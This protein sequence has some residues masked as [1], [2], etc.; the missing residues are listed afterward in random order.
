MK[1][2]EKA[3][4]QVDIV[5]DVVCP[6]CIIG[7]KQLEEAIKR[8]G[9]S[10]DIRWHPFELNPQMVE[11][12]EGIREHMAAKYG[13]TPEGSR[14]ARKQLSDLGAS[15]GI[16]FNYSDETRI[17]PTFRLHQLLHWADTQ[18]RK[19]ELKMAL[20]TAYFTGCKNIN[21][22]D[23]LVATAGS[24]GFDTDEARA[25]LEDGRYADVVREAENTWIGRGIRGVPAMVFN[26]RHLVTGAQGVDRYVGIL[27]ELTENVEA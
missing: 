4:L 16:V 21:D 15:L 24:L 19:H 3:S 10:V 7:Y 23:V 12:G 5:S 20:F 6:W 18:G 9:V 14:A 27:E 2:F 8:T 13:T 25:V 1:P 26:R 22:L 11:E 17:Y